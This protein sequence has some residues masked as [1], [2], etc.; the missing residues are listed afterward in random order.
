MENFKS[1]EN[2]PAPLD[3][4][5]Q[6]TDDG[7]KPEISPRISPLTA[8]FL[9]LLSVFFLYQIGGSLLTYLILGF[10]LKNAD[11]ISIRLLT[12]AGQLLFILLPALLFTRYIYLDVTQ[13]LRF[14]LPDISGVL[15]FTAGLLCLTPLLESYLY[16]QNAILIKLSQIYPFIFKMKEF[17]DKIDKLVE[18]SYS[19][20]LASHSVP[21]GL[22]III[23]VAVVPAIC[24]E[25]FFRGFV[26]KGFEFKLK[27]FTSALITAIFFGLYHFHPYQIVPL[28]A[29]GLYFGY[30]VYLSDSIFTS[31][32][33]HFLNNLF[34][35]IMFFIYGSE[36]IATP[37][38][39]S[40]SE[41]TTSV[42]VFAGLSVL[43]TLIIIYIK[44][45]YYIKRLN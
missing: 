9:G 29:L 41:L 6:Y 21:E 11:V 16:I 32:F 22:M 20:I 4:K 31:I 25:I 18:E 27:P 7:K 38:T 17:I 37:K 3:Q 12:M 14:R 28:T 39:F 35:V 34:A 15:L 36:D 43:F 24:E 19:S 10:N 30:A 26:Q 1:E 23:V 2:N 13:I 44:K 8:S 40:A 45:V 42:M 5:D 33:L